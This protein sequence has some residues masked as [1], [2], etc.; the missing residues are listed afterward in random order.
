M[1]E[2][3]RTK[4]TGDEAGEKKNKF[5]ESCPFVGNSPRFFAQGQ[6]LFFCIGQKQIERGD[7]EYEK[8]RRELGRGEGQI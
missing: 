1:G 6:D 3:C 5:W 7:K 4:G 2:A 8:S